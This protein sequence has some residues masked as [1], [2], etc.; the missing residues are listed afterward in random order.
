MSTLSATIAVQ[1]EAPDIIAQLLRQFPKGRRI[2]VDLTD[3]GE[4]S[5]LVPN[6]EAFMERIEAARKAVPAS[7]WQTTEEALRALREGEEA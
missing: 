2:R 4:V 5:P 7:P 6:L 1:D 3:E